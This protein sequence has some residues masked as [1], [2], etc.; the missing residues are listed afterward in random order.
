MGRERWAGWRAFRGVG[1]IH[2]TQGAGG[3]I[4]WIIGV[5]MYRA[6]LDGGAQN[7]MSG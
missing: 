3:R 6:S 4:F 5:C 7:G 1:S 2:E